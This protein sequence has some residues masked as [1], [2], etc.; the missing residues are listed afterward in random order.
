[1][2]AVLVVGAGRSGTTL[3]DLVLGNREDAVSTGELRFIWRR[4]VIEGQLCGCGTP[5]NRCRFWSRVFE[6]CGF[7][8]TEAK[9]RSRQILLDRVE[10][11]RHIPLRWLSRSFRSLPI[12]SDVI[13]QEWR[14]LEAISRVSKCD[15]V[16]DS[17]KYPGRA[18]ALSEGAAHSRDLYIIHIV[19]DPRAVAHAWTTTKLRPEIV[20]GP[21]PM[22]TYNV[23]ISALTWAAINAAAETLRYAVG[24]RRYLRL[25]YEDF[26]KR[27]DIM[28]ETILRFF[29][30][31]ASPAGGSPDAQDPAA[32]HHTVSGNPIRF[33]PVS[34]V[35]PDE[36]WRVNMS[37][38]DRR[39]VTFLSFPLLLK[40]GYLRRLAD[41]EQAAS[42]R[43]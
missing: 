20:G 29:E 36:K 15:V 12:G 32:I 4:G 33:A 39:I 23:A 25:R 27:P 43:P 42:S 17:S 41:Q 40:Y 3:M 13:E 26:A 6:E 34:S 8:P 16:I 21:S 38:Y 19:R 30:L 7:A 10:R 14:F 37:G 1:M 22:P 28:I 11:F 31:P 35:S 5:L 2:K 9:A 18:L 24:K